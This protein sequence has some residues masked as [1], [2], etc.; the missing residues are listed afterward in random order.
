MT[1]RDRLP[2][3]E[4]KDAHLR[5]EHY[6]LKCSE[7]PTTKLLRCSRCN[8]AWYC[9]KTCQKKHYAEHRTM[10]RQLANIMKFVQ[11]EGLALRS[12]P[13]INIFETGV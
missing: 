9:N 13:G 1:E 5:E 7:T 2:I 10:C 6:C 4:G 8:V 3:Y 11:E 12:V